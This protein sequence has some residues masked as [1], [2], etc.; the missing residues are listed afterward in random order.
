MIKDALKSL[1]PVLYHL[2][3]TSVTII[4]TILY[5]DSW[6]NIYADIGTVRWFI[7][8]N[9]M[10]IVLQLALIKKSPI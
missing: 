1:F 6:V 2:F 8:S 7:F 9:N 3:P 5:F 10:F 4:F